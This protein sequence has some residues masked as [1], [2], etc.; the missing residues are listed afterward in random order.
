MKKAIKLQMLLLVAVVAI[1]SCTTDGK[2]SDSVKLSQ[3]SIT[4]VAGQTANISFS[5][6]NPDKCTVRVGNSKIAQ[7]SIQGSSIVITPK[8]IGNTELTISC[9]S[10]SDKC[11]ITVN[12]STDI[13]DKV[14]FSVGKDAATVWDELYPKLQQYRYTK[15]EIRHNGESMISMIEVE[16]NDGKYNHYDRYSFTEQGLCR[17]EV[18]FLS[19][20]IS[21]RAI[22]DELRNYMQERY[23]E[24]EY[25]TGRSG[26]DAPAEVA[27]VKYSTTINNQTVYLAVEY[28]N[29][30]FGYDESSRY[31]VRAFMFTRD[32]TYGFF[33]WSDL[34]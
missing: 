31:Q 9:G 4:V 29:R 8:R 10:S 28:G 6:G 24:T 19:S 15:S 1:T 2:L 5:S 26:Y 16:Y 30:G 7:A 34:R 11:S 13:L 22:F 32:I 25:N 17:F 23:Q 21:G 3:K 27:Y 14:S 12:G 18:R 20:Y 33:D